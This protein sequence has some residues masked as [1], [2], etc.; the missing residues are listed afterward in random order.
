MYE[1]V[2]TLIFRNPKG[3]YDGFNNDAFFRDRVILSGNCSNF[4]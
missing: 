4:Y 2:E 1:S 3:T